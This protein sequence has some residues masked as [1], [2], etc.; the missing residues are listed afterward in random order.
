M[1]AQTRS[2]AWTDRQW[3]GMETGGVAGPLVVPSVADLRSAFVEVA[4]LGERTR[5]GYT[6]NSERTKWRFDP[7]RLADLAQSVITERDADELDPTASESEVF[8]AIDELLEAGTLAGTTALRYVRSGS[9]LMY[10]HDHSIGDAQALLNLTSV[11]TH[12][13]T[14]GQ[15]PKWVSEELH[16]Q[17]VR[18]AFANTFGP[19]RRSLTKLVA[20]R[21]THPPVRPV[22]K[23]EVG[24]LT[25][26]APK[27]SS[28]TTLFSRQSWQQVKTWRQAHAP[29]ASMASIY[30]VMM[31]RALVKAEFALTAD[32]KILYDCRRHLPRGV[33]LRGNFVV[34]FS[35]ELADDPAIA[36]DQI[37]ETASSGRVLMTLATSAAKN[38]LRSPAPRVSSVA[39][40]PEME[41]AFVFAPRSREIEV[42]PWQR[43]DL[44]AFGALS[45]TSG[46]TEITLSMMIL[47]GRLAATWSFHSNVV[48]ESRIREATRLMEEDPLGLLGQ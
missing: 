38:L 34:G 11:L 41:V 7:S 9:L 1:A 29:E 19:G 45:T 21:L 14:T 2:I 10:Q 32:T 24:P 4:S 39:A 36:G 3:V 6:F 46:P 25:E 20:Q 43:P 47:A 31:R 17:P 28:V 48:P 42:L 27:L 18:T 40:D 37:A 5:L 16:P 13:A 26:W 12:V 33:H 30:A 35:Q 23:T 22:S 44:H 15:L 8:A